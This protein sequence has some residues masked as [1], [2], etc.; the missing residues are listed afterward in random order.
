MA[1]MQALP[2]PPQSVAGLTKEA[3]SPFKLA[4]LV[5][6]DKYNRIGFKYGEAITKG[7]YVLAIASYVICKIAL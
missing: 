7:S 3:L 6:I 5:F 1:A 2:T 4:L